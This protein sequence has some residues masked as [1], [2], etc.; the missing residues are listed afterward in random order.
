[1]NTFKQEIR[2]AQARDGVRIAYAIAGRGYPMIRATHWL[3]NIEFDWQ[4]PTIGAI[5]AGYSRRCRLYRYNP[6]GYGLSEGEGT[7]LSLDSFV[8]DLEAVVDAAGL[9]RFALN[10]SSGGAPIAIAYAAKHPERVSHLVLV[11]AF[12]RGVLRRNPTPQQ[13]ERFYATAKLVELGWGED[14]PGIRQLFTSEFF[15]NATLEQMRAF[16][17]LQR[18]SASPHQAAQMLLVNADLD[19][20]HLLDRIRAPTIVLNCRGDVRVPIEE[21][22]L[23]A[24]RI[25]NARF[26][27][28]DSDNHVPLPSESAFEQMFDEIAAFLANTSEPA[29]RQALVSALTA[30][31]LQV[32]DLIARGRDNAQIAAVFGLSEKTVRNHITSIFD[33]LAV[34]TRAQAIVL[35]REAGLGV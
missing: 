2:F 3:T 21:G 28:L 17:E 24:S 13:V 20:V 15:P 18:Q 32:L 9:K 19:V 23:M 6:R 11:G 33:K 12:A 26:V 30:R 27:P 29:G 35:A 5:L 16:N 25:H 7:E 34:A 22:R 1:M 8:A 10:G 14:N 31:E 4:S